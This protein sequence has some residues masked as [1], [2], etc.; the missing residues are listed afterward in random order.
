MR[1]PH[2]EG[3]AIHSAPSFALD[4]ARCAAKRKQGN[5]WAGYGASK[6]CNQDADAVR[7]AEGHMTRGASAS[8]WA[9]LRSRRPQTRLD[10][11]CTRTGRPRR[12][13]PPYMVAGRR[14][15]A[16][17]VQPACTSA[18]SRTVAEYR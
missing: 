12:Y 7:V 18:R 14:E 3:V 16:I 17:A 5:R 15:K 13:R 9:V 8:S 11:F 2:E 4:A 10:T 1:D 6:M